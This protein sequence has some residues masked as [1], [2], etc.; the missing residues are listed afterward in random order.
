MSHPYTQGHWHTGALTHRSVSQG[1]WTID[2]SVHVR[3][4]E[5]IALATVM[6]LLD[7]LYIVGF[8]SW[9][10][11]YFNV[12]E[13]SLVVSSILSTFWSIL[14]LAHLPANTV[15]TEAHS[16][17]K[18]IAV[19]YSS[20]STKALDHQ[21]LLPFWKIKEGNTHTYTI[22]LNNRAFQEQKFK[23]KF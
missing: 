8:H 13:I 2:G 9:V 16:T 10:W 15:A 1:W 23:K 21:Y 20:S 19:F 6:V 22:K 7:T 11:T 3:N 4:M 14:S 12:S 17:W 18:P 5:Q